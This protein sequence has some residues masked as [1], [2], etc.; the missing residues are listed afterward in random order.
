MTGHR[1]LQIP[2]IALVLLLYQHITLAGHLLLTIEVIQGDGTGLVV[3]VSVLADSVNLHIDILQLRIS[4]ENIR[5]I[6]HVAELHARLDIHILHL[7]IGDFI[8]PLTVG[9]HLP[10]GDHLDLT[11]GHTVLLRLLG[12]L[13]QVEH[14]ARELIT[15]NMP[16]THLTDE[17]R[18]GNAVG[19]LL[20]ISLLEIQRIDMRG[21]I[22]QDLVG[23]LLL[24]GIMDMQEIRHTHPEAG[25]GLTDTGEDALLLLGELI[26]GILLL[27]SEG[28]QQALMATRTAIVCKGFLGNIVTHLELGVLSAYLLPLRGVTHHLHD[29]LPLLGILLTHHLGPQMGIFMDRCLSRADLRVNEDHAVLADDTVGTATVTQ[30][31]AHLQTAGFLGKGE[32]FIQ[33]DIDA[34]LVHVVDNRTHHT[35]LTEV[36]ER[37]VHLT[38]LVQL[39][40]GLNV[41][42]GHDLTMLG[43]IAAIGHVLKLTRHILGVLGQRMTDLV[44]G[45]IHPAL[46]ITSLDLSGGIG[47]L[48]IH[49]R[50]IIEVIQEGFIRLI[51]VLLGNTLQLLYI[52]IGKRVVANLL[53]QL[54]TDIGSRADTLYTTALEEVVVGDEVDGTKDVQLLI[55]ELTI[56]R[57]FG[58]ALDFLDMVLYL[59]NEDATHLLTSGHA[60]ATGLIGNILADND[61]A[62]H[63]EQLLRIGIDIQ[64]LGLMIVAANLL[65]GDRL[66]T[67]GHITKVGIGGIQLRRIHE[68]GKQQL[69]FLHGL[70]RAISL[71]EAVIRQTLILCLLL[72]GQRLAHLHGSGGILAVKLYP[73][74]QL[75]MF[76]L[77]TGITPY[78]D[79]PEGRN[80]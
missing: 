1:S 8:T 42:G 38:V 31:L 27:Q 20:G 58:E 12:E 46:G 73:S 54:L 36:I 76:T 72:L 68:V 15:G 37:H 34:G 53:L 51:A 40:V 74:L 4:T 62:K 69:T 17:M 9:T 23:N 28:S 7:G 47:I 21:Q 45:H 33:I 78:V 52:I 64:L 67:D 41:K 2:Q 79:L 39:L 19:E 24:G 14:E 29:G 30:E 43:L 61:A 32:V 25:D 48:L 18:T 16:C 26:D 63:L 80:L 6:D 57:T 44:T 71:D 22:L 5:S 49:R 11:V 60:Q 65:I 56:V 55:G 77:I 50:D 75:R 70:H 35:G 59:V 10:A 3:V 66:E 13:Q